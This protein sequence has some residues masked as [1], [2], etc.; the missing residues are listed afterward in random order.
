MASTIG[1]QLPTAAGLGEFEREASLTLGRYL[2]VAASLTMGAVGLWSMHYVGNRSVIMTDGAF[3]VQILYNTGFAVGSFFLPVSLVS[4]AFFV[5]GISENVGVF[6]A[7]FGGLLLS[8][9]VCGMHYLGQVGIFNYTPVYS[10]GYIA[11]AAVIAVAAST[12]ALGLFFY[13]NSELTDNWFKRLA[14]GSLLAT[15]V[16][17]MHWMATVGTSYKYKTP[18]NGSHNGLDRTTTTAVVISLVRKP[19]HFSICEPKLT[20]LGNRLF[21]DSCDSWPIWAPLEEDIG[22]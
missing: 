15:A 2:L 1:R 19:P 17:G 6:R 4:G 11:G 14:C 9:S 20:C 10:P 12:V 7:L 8:L 22:H 16:S 5:F 18:P 21:S 13:L 3:D